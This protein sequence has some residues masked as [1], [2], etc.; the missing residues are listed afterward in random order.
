MNS[1][2]MMTRTGRMNIANQVCTCSVSE[3]GVPVFIPVYGKVCNHY[4]L[5]DSH[6][7]TF[8]PTATTPSNLNLQ[9]CELSETHHTGR[10]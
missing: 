4:K 1:N 3:D 2:A 10:S 5:Q 7:L 8:L 6:S 9:L